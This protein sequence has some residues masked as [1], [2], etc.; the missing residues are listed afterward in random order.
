MEHC[1]KENMKTRA[2]TGLL[3]WFFSG[4]L[5]SRIADIDQRPYWNR[6][7]ICKVQKANKSV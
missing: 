5:V 3:A 4:A 1:L 7:D 2:Y 6:R